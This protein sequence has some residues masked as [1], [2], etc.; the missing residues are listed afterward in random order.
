MENIEI[1]TLVDI[2]NT[3]VA[4]NNQGSILEHDQYRNFTTLMQCVG[5]RCIIEYD[6]NPI[7]EEID[8]TDMGF[9]SAY[10]G[11]HRVW[12]F[13]FRPDRTLAFEDESNP[14]GLLIHDMHEVPVIKTLTET[15]NIDKAVFFTYESQWKNTIIKAHQGTV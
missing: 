2:T 4:R 9:G 12:T 8:I 5:L 7:V 1:R 13:S 11:K 10:K 14:V 3:K 15:I 6:D